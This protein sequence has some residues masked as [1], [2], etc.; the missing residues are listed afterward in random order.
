MCLSKYFSSS[1]GGNINKDVKDHTGQRYS[2]GVISISA[3]QHVHTIP[4]H[5]IVKFFF[6]SKTTT[7]NV[8]ILRY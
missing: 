7:R 3:T 2:K 6:F 1:N 5:K 8:Q 4:V